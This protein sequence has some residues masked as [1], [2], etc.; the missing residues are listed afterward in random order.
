MGKNKA[1][2]PFR[3]EWLE[4]LRSGEY[5]KGRGTLRNLKDEF[6]CL[7]VYCDILAKKGM[8]EWNPMKDDNY[9]NVYSFSYKGV[10]ET[11][12]LPIGVVKS[13]GFIDNNGIGPVTT[14]TQQC[15]D[16]TSLND[17][18]GKAA[19][20]FHNIAKVIEANTENIPTIK[21]GKKY[22][23]VKEL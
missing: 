12:I 9:K 23:V 16:L 20:S 19:L 2:I 7:G 4:A 21:K 17:G 1:K 18:D 3:D 14:K 11:S 5:K 22:F 15:M 6:C 13:F 10:K 8:G